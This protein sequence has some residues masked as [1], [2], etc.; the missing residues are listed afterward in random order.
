MTTYIEYL[1]SDYRDNGTS[2]NFVYTIQPP[3]KFDRVVV[4]SASIPKT[5]F[6]VQEGQNTLTI[7][8]NGIQ[9]LITLPEGNYGNNTF[10]PSL[11]SLLNTGSVLYSFII[12]PA[13]TYITITATGGAFTSLDFPP[14]SALYRQL[15]F[16]YDTNNA[17]IDN[18][19][20][21]K[22]IPLFQLTNCVYIKSN[23]CYAQGSQLSANILE[24]INASNQPNLY[25]IEYQ[26][27]TDLQ[28]TAKK[29]DYAQIA[30]NFQITNSD[31]FILNTGG[32]PVTMKLLFFNADDSLQVLK[33]K[34]LLDNLSDMSRTV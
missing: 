10:M 25:Y 15:G 22:N 14:T 8:E 5:Y 32:L 19:I 18:T 13:T 9:R 20:T 30:V 7:T 23:L 17:V 16:D 11:I 2:T 31:G 33:S 6:L 21:S 27:T 28:L 12:N 24:S 4:L 1:D 29:Y 3:E 26:C 34:A